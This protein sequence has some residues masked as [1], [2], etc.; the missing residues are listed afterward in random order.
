MSGENVAVLM[1]L[2]NSPAQD[3]LFSTPRLISLIT[4]AQVFSGQ[5]D[6]AQQSLEHLVNF[7]P[8]PTAKLQADLLAQWQAFTGWIAHLRG[9][10]EPAQ[11]H[12]HAALQWLSNRKSTRLNSSH[13]RI[14]YAVFCL[15]KKKKKTKKKKT[16]IKNK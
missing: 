16:K 15:K 8:Q 11:E 7:L 9:A 13:V 3:I 12:L 6:S 5:L 4:G 1:Q 14:S 2:R 10:A